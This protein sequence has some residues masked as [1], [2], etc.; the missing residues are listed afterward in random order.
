[1]HLNPTGTSRLAKNILSSIKSFWKAKG[2]PCIIIENNIEPEH[3]SVFD[4]EMPTSINRN[5]NQPEKRNLKVLT[6]IRLKDRNRLIIGQL[7]TNSIQNKFDFLCSKI[8]PSLDL[9][10]VS[11]TKLDYPF[12]TAQF[13]MSGFCKP[14][15]S[16]RCSDCGGLLLYIRNTI[17]FTYWV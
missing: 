4:S 2:C 16:D 13:L 17:S 3:P 7:N 8:S 1:M 5:E 9:L 14:Y 10:L 6:N 12:P 11:E 15:R